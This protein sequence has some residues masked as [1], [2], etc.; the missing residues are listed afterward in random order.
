MVRYTTLMDCHPE[1][2]TLTEQSSG[3][4]VMQFL[5]YG[6]HS[7]PRLYLARGISTRMVSRW[8]HTST[9]SVLPL[10][11][12]DVANAALPAMISAVAPASSAGS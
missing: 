6:C 1:F 4:Y 7:S 5:N 9:V 2:G 8:V 12:M 11:R 3:S 10:T